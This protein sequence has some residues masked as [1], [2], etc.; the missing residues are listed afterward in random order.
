MTTE[1]DSAQSRLPHTTDNFVYSALDHAT[2]Q[3]R[4]LRI[5]PGKSK[6]R[7]ICTIQHVSLL[8]MDSQYNCLSYTWG[9][10][11]NTRTIL[12]NGKELKVRENLYNF[13]LRA[14]KFPRIYSMPIWIDAVCLDQANNA[15]KSHQVQRMSSIYASAKRVFIWLG[16]EHRKTLIRSSFWTYYRLYVDGRRDFGSKLAFRASEVVSHVRDCCRTF[17]RFLV[18]IG[19]LKNYL[20]YSNG[21]EHAFTFKWLRLHID[22]LDANEYWDR[23][24]TVQERI[25]ARDPWI[26]YQNGFLPYPP[27][28]HFYSVR[29]PS[30][31]F[32][33]PWDLELAVDAFRTFECHD[34]RDRLYALRSLL[35]ERDADAIV[36]DYDMDLITLFLSQARRWLLTNLSSY[37]DCMYALS[38]ALGLDYVTYC[39]HQLMDYLRSTATSQKS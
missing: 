11:L 4:V 32:R 8:A 31:N 26:V 16:S 29:L 2:E 7:I 1:T 12:V 15:E 23:I 25:L 27:L 13:L 20:P 35:I 24:W 37:E 14:R 28:Y 6:E 17:D 18:S 30:W 3:I 36:V 21:L 39:N 33:T 38:K 5:Q 9:D 34:P 10:D 19:I 22:V